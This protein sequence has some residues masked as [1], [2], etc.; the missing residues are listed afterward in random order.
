MSDAPRPPLPRGYAQLL[1]NLANE[2]G[3]G[4]LDR[5]GRVVVGPGRALLAGGPEA[6]LRLVAEGFIA[7]ERGKVFVTEAGRA[8]AQRYNEGCTAGVAG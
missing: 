4:E 7:G 3:A 1:C 8:E 6:W 5:Y 2:G